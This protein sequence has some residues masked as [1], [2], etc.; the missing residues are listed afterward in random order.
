[1]NPVCRRLAPLVLAALVAP[2]AQAL[3]AEPATAKPPPAAKPAGKLMTRD[4]LRVCLDERDQRQAQRARLQADI[5]ASDAQRAELNRRSAEIA[6]RRAALDPANPA[7]AEVLQADIVKQDE[8]VDRYNQQLRALASASASL[9][10]SR[11]DYIQR[12]ETRPYD[13]RDEIAILRER[14]NAAKAPAKK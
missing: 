9:E 5:T 14:R 11:A 12:C 8:Q 4:E 1:M 6:Q 3:A 13:E 10:S 2:A 7:A